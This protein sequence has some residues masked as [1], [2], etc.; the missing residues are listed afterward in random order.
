VSFTGSTEVGR[1]VT[2]SNLKPV[3]LELGG[4]PP[5]LYFCFSARA[6]VGGPGGAAHGGAT[7]PLG[8]ADAGLQR[9]RGR[10][11]PWQEPGRGAR[12]RHHPLELPHTM[13]SFVKVSH[14]THRRGQV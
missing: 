6:K 14:R 2:E 12:W 7:S 10:Q 3:W 5:G 11:D 1:L 9:G 13:M 8:G 4:R